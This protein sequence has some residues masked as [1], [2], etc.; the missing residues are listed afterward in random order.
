MKKAENLRKI[1][2][3]INQKQ[4]KNYSLVNMGGNKYW[5]HN[6]DRKAAWMWLKVGNL[7]YLLGFIE[8]L[9]LSD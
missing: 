1:L 5:I 3:E 2:E 8:G 9:F 4:N 6:G 7:D